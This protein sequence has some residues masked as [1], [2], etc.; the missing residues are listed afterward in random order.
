MTIAAKLV[1]GLLQSQSSNFAMR[2]VAGNA[3]FLFEGAV[4]VLPGEFIQLMA[5]STGAPLREFLALFNLSRSCICIQENNTQD[6]DENQSRQPKA[7]LAEARWQP[8]LQP[9]THRFLSNVHEY[10]SPLLSSYGKIV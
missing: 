1:F 10:F 3:I 8:C 4:L 9:A 7:S 5:I 6:K 2:L